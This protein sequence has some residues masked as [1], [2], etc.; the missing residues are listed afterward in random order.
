MKKYNHII[1]I[2]NL[3]K[4]R[5]KKLGQYFTTNNILKEKLYE[6]ILNDPLNIL[7][8]SIGQGDK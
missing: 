6:F 8:P 5:V 7:E 2:M 1:I 4:Q 3:T